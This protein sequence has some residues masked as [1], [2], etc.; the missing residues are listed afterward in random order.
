MITTVQ[1]SIPS[2]LKNKPR[3]VV[4]DFRLHHT[5]SIIILLWLHSLSGVIRSLLCNPHTFS[6]A[7]ITSYT[8]TQSS[9]V[10][11]HSDFASTWRYN[12]LH[13]AR[14]H[15]L[16]KNNIKK[17]FNKVGGASKESQ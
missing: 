3:V 13:C 14:V 5:C 11:A 8:P 10:H 17:I 1:C 2:Q 15:E 7:I 6:P 9:D 16:V 4:T 12:Y